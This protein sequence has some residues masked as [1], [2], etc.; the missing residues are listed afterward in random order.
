MRAT[1]IR[2]RPVRNDVRR[3]PDPKLAP[4]AVSRPDQFDQFRLVGGMVESIGR[5]FCESALSNGPGFRPDG[6]RA[7]SS[8]AS[9]ATQVSAKLL[10]SSL[11]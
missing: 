10:S 6:G 1:L 9:R 2:V 7:L 4:V 8:L 5:R 3:A 11:R